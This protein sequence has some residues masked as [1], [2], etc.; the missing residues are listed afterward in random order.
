MNETI[1]GVLSKIL[2]MEAKYNMAAG[3]ASSSRKK[4]HYEHV[5]IIP[6][7]KRLSGGEQIFY[8]EYR[9]LIALLSGFNFREAI[10]ILYGCIVSVIPSAKLTVNS[11]EYC[12][13]SLATFRITVFM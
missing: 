8:C 3:G 2:L 10:Y 9:V 12:R 7:A 4:S 11:F 1:K 6:T 5:Q 13:I